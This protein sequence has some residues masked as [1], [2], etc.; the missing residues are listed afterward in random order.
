[1]SAAKLPRILCVDD[2]ARVL[3]GL[4]LS[5]RRE[6]DV[7]TA[8]G[9]EKALQKLKELRGVAVVIS[10]MRMPGM[11]GAQLLQRI[12]REWPETTRILLTGEPGRDAAI[13]AVNQAQI[14]RFLTKPCPPEQLKT[15]VE[16]GVMQFKLMNAERMILQETVLGCIQA[17]VDVLAITNPVAFGRANRVKRHAMDFAKKLQ[18]QDFWQLEAAAMLSQIGYVSLPVE[19]CE[20]L[21]YGHRLTPEESTLAE[22]VPQ[23]ATN[24]LQHIPRLEPV[25]QV[26]TALQWRDEQIMR[27]GDGTIGM[28]TRILAMV[29]EY[30][31][32]ITRGVAISSAVKTMHERV[33][34]YGAELLEK[35]AAYVGSGSSKAELRE[36]PLREVQSGMVMM[37]EVRTDEGTLLAPRGL[38]IGP[39][40]L[41]RMRTFGPG[42]L[43]EQVKVLVPGITAGAAV[44]LPA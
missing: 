23:I 7:H 41:E 21:Y 4:V 2:E 36:L 39:A 38:E 44:A 31:G 9:G 43:A 3:E 14:F 19:L 35:F 33:G 5:L 6:F 27:L 15:A 18:Y 20:K 42:L 26:L 8:L 30:D 1:M 32:L 28:A 29:L 11:D 16:A 40:F 10:D 22:G 24:L 25:T 37:Q 17:L 12:L 34:R 13:A